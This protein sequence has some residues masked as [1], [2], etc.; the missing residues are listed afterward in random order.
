MKSIGQQHIVAKDLSLSLRTVYSDN[1]KV[2]YI[3][4]KKK[5]VLVALYDAALDVRGR[6]TWKI[7]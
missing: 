4:L 6:S 3:V 5:Q 2:G 7:Q 1:G